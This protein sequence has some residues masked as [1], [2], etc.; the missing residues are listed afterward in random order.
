MALSRLLRTTHTICLAVLFGVIM[1]VTLPHESKAAE[2]EIT[3]AS[4]LFPPARGNPYSNALVPSIWIYE[5]MFDSLTRIGKAGR[6]EPALALAW[7]QI[8]PLEWRVTLRPDVRF[9][10]G[11]AFDASAVVAAFDYLSSDEGQTTAVARQWAQLPVVTAEDPETVLFQTI[12]PDPILIR[13]LAAIRI[14]AP[15][16]LAELGMTEFA[17]APA[18][19]GP[20]T[21]ESWST[22]RI[23]LTAFEGSWRPPGVDRLTFLRIPEPIARQQALATGSVDIAFAMNVEFEPVLEAI[24]GSLVAE[25]SAANQ[26][27][28]FRT[29]IDGPLQDV[30]VRQ[31]LNYAVN[32]N[33]MVDLLLGGRSEVAS[34]PAPSDVPGHVDEL[35]PYEYDPDRA[36]QLLSEAGYQDGFSLTIEAPNAGGSNADE[37][38][39][40]VASDLRRVG[41]EAEVIT[42]PNMES[43]RRIAQGGWEGG[44]FLLTTDSMPT[45]DPLRPFFVASCAWPSQWHCNAAQSAL[46]EAADKEPDPQVRLGMIQ[47]LQRQ[48]HEDPPYLYLIR[49]VNFTAVGPR[50]QGFETNF[51]I[52]AYHQLTLGAGR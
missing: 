24:G 26:V 37:I 43:G 28:A 5:A 3:V 30:R 39:V 11:E 17:A 20:F 1:A 35:T 15:Q 9:S 27:I 36:R 33:A 18:G 52:I 44:A 10:N 29:G 8:G 22:T 14:A 50:V 19:T 6:V 16:R 4:P 25:R 51:G 31:A 49:L 41:V 46:S 23:D 45:L 7:D 40:L 34:Q 38:Y 42:F 21:V 13:R 2:A 47:D 12:Q 32:K 48:F